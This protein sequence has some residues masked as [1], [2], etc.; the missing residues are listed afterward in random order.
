[1]V[2]FFFFKQKT[3]YEMLRSLVGS[4]MCIRD[5]YQRRVRGP[6]SSLDSP[7][8]VADLLR[9]H[10]LINACLTAAVCLLEVLVW[11]AGGEPS[12]AYVCGIAVNVVT[13]RG[14]GYMWNAANRMDRGEYT[15]GARSLVVAAACSAARAAWFLS[16]GLHGAFLAKSQAPTVISVVYRIMVAVVAGA[17]VYML[18]VLKTMAD[19]WSLQVISPQGERCEPLLAECSCGEQF[20]KKVAGRFYTR[21]PGEFGGSSGDHVLP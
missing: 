6:S 18:V 21:D 20:E 12:W 9:K 2:F 7:A 1:M 14:V 10:A 13:S 4:E 15:E 17:Y 19:C 5:R 3:A 8:S 11:A 16:V